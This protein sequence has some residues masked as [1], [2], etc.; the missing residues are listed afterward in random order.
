M[1]F[2]IAISESA[3]GIWNTQV[4]TRY[5]NTQNCTFASENLGISLKPYTNEYDLVAREAPKICAV[6]QSAQSYSR[7][8]ISGFLQAFG[9]E[10]LS[11]ACWAASG[12]ILATLGVSCVRP[13]AKVANVGWRRSRLSGHWLPDQQHSLILKWILWGW[14]ETL[15]LLLMCFLLL[16][17]H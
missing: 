12:A 7:A 1:G 2:F 13:L 3:L 9:A 14:G 16:N 5:Q 4:Y 11:S 17:K 6:A 8:V 15:K 10:A